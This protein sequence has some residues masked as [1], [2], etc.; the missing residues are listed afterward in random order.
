MIMIAFFICRAVAVSVMSLEV[1]PRCIAPPPTGHTSEKA[2]T[3]AMTSCLISASISS[4][5]VM[6]TLL[7]ERSMSLYSAS[8]ISPREK[9][10]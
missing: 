7:S 9:C 8:L 2:L 10:A 5:L 1:A 3:M 6:L 4:A